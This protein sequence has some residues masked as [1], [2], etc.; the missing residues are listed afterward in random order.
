MQLLVDQFEKFSGVL[1]QSANSPVTDAEFFALCAQYPD[2]RLET[3][4]EGDILIRRTASAAAQEESGAGIECFRLGFPRP[5]KR[6]W[7]MKPRCG[8]LRQSL[9]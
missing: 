6:D 8:M 3:T 1:L 9:S 4:A 2:Y 5:I 7:P